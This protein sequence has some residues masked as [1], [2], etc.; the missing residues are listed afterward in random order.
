M[1]RTQKDT[2]DLKCGENK[3]KNKLLPLKY[4]EKEF[5]FDIKYRDGY[6]AIKNFSSNYYLSVKKIR[7]K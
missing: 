6:E 2:L 3:I 7:L 1:Y 5:E 4:T